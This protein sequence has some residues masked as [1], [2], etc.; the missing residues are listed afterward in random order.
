MD[1][2][3]Q[4]WEKLGA[5]DPYWAVLTDPAKADGKWDQAE[6]FKTGE[7]EI[8]RVLRRVGDLGVVPEPGVALDF[9]C[10]VG[11]LSRALSRHFKEVLA[12]D[13]SS[14]MLKEAQVANADIAHITWIHNPASDLQVVPSGSVDFV[15]SNITL[16]HM[17][18][19][20]QAG[21][22]SEFCRVLRPGGIVA[23]QSPTRYK[24]GNVRGW[25]YRV[26]GYQGLS[27]LRQLR[28][29]GVGKMEVYPLEKSVVLEIFAREGMNVQATDAN[30]AAGPEFEGLFYVAAKCGINSVS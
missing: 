25:V 7:E 15:Y 26:I 22:V 20:Q 16:Q 5:D 2:Y 14:S 29:G 27:L 18:P 10:G 23:F 28:Y 21:Y 24:A 30:E 9:G 4:V 3:R 8:A 1:R 12:V 19:A 13:V 17:P 11:R 6:F